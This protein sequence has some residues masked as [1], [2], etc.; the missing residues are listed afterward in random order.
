MTED[1]IKDLELEI[2]ELQSNLK[3]A[4]RDL[5]KLDALEAFGVDNWEGYSEAMR[6]LEE[7]DED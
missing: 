1:R 2:M 4:Q 7:D 3:E 5:R 6:S